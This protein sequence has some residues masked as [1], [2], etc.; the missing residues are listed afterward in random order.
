[1]EAEDLES[2]SFKPSMPECS[3]ESADIMLWGTHSLIYFYL[4]KNLLK[5]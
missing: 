3:V 2:D 5:G 1:M 4:I